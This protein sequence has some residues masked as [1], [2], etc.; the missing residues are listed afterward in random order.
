MICKLVFRFCLTG[1]ASVFVS[2]RSNLGVERVDTFRIVGCVVLIG[3]NVQGENDW[4][5][6]SLWKCLKVILDHLFV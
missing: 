6:L 5:A 2:L 4:V 1:L 3:F